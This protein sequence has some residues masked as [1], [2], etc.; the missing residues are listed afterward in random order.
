MAV[1]R[2][3]PRPVAGPPNFSEGRQEFP[4][5]VW[6]SPEID[7][8]KFT[9]HILSH[10]PG[11]FQGLRYILLMLCNMTRRLG[12]GKHGILRQRARWSVRAVRAFRNTGLFLTETR[13]VADVHSEAWASSDFLI[14]F[15]SC[16]VPLL[17]TGA[18][19][20]TTTSYNRLVSR[21]DINDWWIPSHRL[22]YRKPSWDLAQDEDW[23]RTDCWMTIVW[24]WLLIVLACIWMYGDKERWSAEGKYCRMYLG[25]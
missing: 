12:D 20:C 2:G 21:D 13:V 19:S 17:M 18:L 8:S 1:T 3:A 7:L 16:L 24:W 9:L 5:R 15:W 11:R 10:A 25:T 14:C 6:Y 23:W 4:P 22:W